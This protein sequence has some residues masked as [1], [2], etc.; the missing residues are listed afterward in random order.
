MRK[1]GLVGRYSSA[2]IKGFVVDAAERLRMSTADQS[3][4]CVLSAAESLRRND[5]QDQ[6][7]AQVMAELQHE[8][9]LFRYPISKG[10]TLQD[11]FADIHPTITEI[12][13]QSWRERVVSV[14]F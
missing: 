11:T 9:A 13:R 14:Q 6:F 4:A 7:A 10:H 2:E 12:G 3:R 5:S 8:D 1:A